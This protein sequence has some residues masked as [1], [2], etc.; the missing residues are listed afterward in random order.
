VEQRVVFVIRIR[1]HQLHQELDVCLMRCR[2]I[3]GGRVCID[4]I[5]ASSGHE[6]QSAKVMLAQVD[7]GVSH[8]NPRMVFSPPELAE[9]ELNRLQ[10]REQD[11]IWLDRWLTLDSSCAM[12]GPRRYV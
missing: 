6:T 10:S 9:R 1:H 4:D 3:V 5:A 7:R 8:S 11:G 2:G 12:M